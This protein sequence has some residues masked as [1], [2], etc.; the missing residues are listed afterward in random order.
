[1]I[2]VRGYG[3]LYGL[4]IARGYFA[5]RLVDFKAYPTAREPFGRHERRT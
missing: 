2:G 4:D 1:L 5:R 3:V